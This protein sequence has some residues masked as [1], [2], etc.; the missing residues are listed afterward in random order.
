MFLQKKKKGR[1]KKK[2]TSLNNSGNNLWNLS[3][4]EVAQTVVDSFTTDNKKVS[5]YF[6]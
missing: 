4:Q 1:K 5:G 3:A 6:P 2:E